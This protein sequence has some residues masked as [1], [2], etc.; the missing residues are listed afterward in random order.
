VDPNTLLLILRIAIAASLYIFLAYILIHLWKD[1]QTSKQARSIAPQSYLETLKGEGLERTFKLEELNLIGR[2]NDNTI[3][4]NDSTVSG[5]HARISYQQD[6]WWLEDL[7]SRNG[8]MLNEIQ[9]TEP[10]VI[11]SS[12]ELQFGNIRMRVTSGSIPDASSHP[13]Q[14]ENDNQTIPQS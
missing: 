6:Q 2:A 14:S 9:V 8:T 4:L 1:I 3:V 13:I 7:G 11:T 10:L 5:Y 12:D